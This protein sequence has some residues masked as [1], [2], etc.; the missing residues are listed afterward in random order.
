M[1]RGIKFL[2]LQVKIFL[3]GVGIFLML[4]FTISCVFGHSYTKETLSYLKED[5]VKVEKIV[6]FPA[7]SML[8]E[9]SYE[10]AYI[11]ESAL[12]DKLEEI[13]SKYGVKVIPEE[14]VVRLLLK[15]PRNVLVSLYSYLSGESK[16]SEHEE[17]L[18]KIQ[19]LTGADIA[20]VPFVYT[21]VV[22]VKVKKRATSSTMEEE[23]WAEGNAT[24]FYVVVSFISLPDGRTVHQFIYGDCSKGGLG[25]FAECKFDPVNTDKVGDLISDALE[26]FFEEISG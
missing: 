14:K 17:V 6:Q 7:L 11:Y 21:D 4:F 25:E 18:K 13:S 9:C 20:A 10:S 16:F 12:S 23:V 24:Y 19:Q 26:S 15:Y 5:R 1:K 8:G 22:E 2:L 3:Q